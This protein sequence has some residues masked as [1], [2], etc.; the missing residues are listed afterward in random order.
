MNP[1]HPPGPPMV[2]SPDRMR[3]HRHNPWVEGED[4][5]P[6]LALLAMLAIGA[7]A[8]GIALLLMH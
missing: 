6:L 3:Q 5:D 7:A 2:C 8:A 4:A 1:K